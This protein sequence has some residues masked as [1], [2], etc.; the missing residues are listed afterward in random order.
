MV[1]SRLGVLRLRHTLTYPIKP[2]KLELLLLH[3]AHA[4]TAA[5]RRNARRCASARSVLLP[6]RVVADR[7][8]RR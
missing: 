6:G 1:R 8:C 5:T 3:L 7:H 2:V 4:K